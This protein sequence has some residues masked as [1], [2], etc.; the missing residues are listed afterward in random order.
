[1]Q[2]IDENPEKLKPPW[3][4]A[5]FNFIS[6]SPSRK[7]KTQSH[8]QNNSQGGFYIFTN[9]STVLERIFEIFSTSYAKRC[10][11]RS[12]VSFSGFWALLEGRIFMFFYFNWPLLEGDFGFNLS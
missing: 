9:Q 11:W 10:S 6:K 8:L 2:I 3:G 5:F 12:F 1:M 7:N 4:T